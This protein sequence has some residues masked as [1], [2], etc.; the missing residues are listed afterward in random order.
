VKW[1]CPGE[2]DRVPQLDINQ[3][4]VEGI[5]GG[6][7]A[8]SFIQLS[9]SDM[10]SSSSLLHTCTRWSAMQALRRKLSICTRNGYQWLRSTSP[11]LPVVV[12]D[13][14]NSERSGYYSSSRPTSSTNDLEAL[15]VFI[16]SFLNRVHFH[17]RHEAFSLSEFR[18]GPSI[19]D[20]RR[21]GGRQV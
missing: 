9:S 7:W 13:L 6:S 15:P 16:L 1:Q 3:E 21:D 8:A 5:H 19:K 2:E 14:S 12:A 4:Q 11:S 18:K 20:V 17:Q 10:K